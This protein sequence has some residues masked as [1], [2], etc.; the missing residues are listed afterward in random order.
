MY[1]QT[2]NKYKIFIYSPDSAETSSKSCFSYFSLDFF[3]K[4]LWFQKKFWK[5]YLFK[6]GSLFSEGYLFEYSLYYFIFYFFE[7][8]PFWISEIVYSR[9]ATYS[10]NDTCLNI[11]NSLFS[12]R[13]L[14]EYSKQLILGKILI[15]SN[16]WN[17]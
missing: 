16:I 12:E 1:K 8:I 14:F 10:W 11:R 17:K 5:G 13:Y 7:K 6:I 3:Y 9:K 4:I 15:I 2:N